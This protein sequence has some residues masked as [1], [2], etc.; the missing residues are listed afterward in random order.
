MTLKQI[1][2]IIGVKLIKKNQTL[3][4]AE[5]CTGG[6]ISAAIT[7]I[8]GASNYF[9]GGLVS[10]ANH[11]K[12]EL[13]GVTAKTLRTQGAVSKETALMMARGARRIFKS[14]WAVSV[15]GIAG[16]SGGT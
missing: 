12:S 14:D 6:L 16:P 11:T 7:E 10:Y 4:M 15:T 13:L 2:K 9:Y 8:P 1:S 3:G 5:S